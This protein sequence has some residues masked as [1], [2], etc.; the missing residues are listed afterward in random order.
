MISSD[1]KSTHTNLSNNAR[2]LQVQ[3]FETLG[4]LASNELL[5]NVMSAIVLPAIVSSLPLASGSDETIICLALNCVAQLI[6][7]PKNAAAVAK[8]GFV[9]YLVEL[10]ISRSNSASQILSETAAVTLKILH[11]L[12]SQGSHV[13]HSL[14]ANGAVNVLTQLLKIQNISG[15]ETRLACETLSVLITDAFRS[16][17]LKEYLVREIASKETFMRRL[18]ATMIAH[19]QQETSIGIPPVYETKY[20]G[21]EFTVAIRLLV[22]IASLLCS[23]YGSKGRL[24]DILLFHD[25]PDASLAAVYACCSLLRILQN[26]TY[27]E[28]RSMLTVGTFLLEATSLSLKEC[29]PNLNNQAEEIIVSFQVPQLCL[30]MCQK[31]DAT[32]AFELFDVLI[33]RFGSKSIGQQLLAEKSSLMALLNIVTVDNSNTHAFARFLGDLAKDGFLSD[34]IAV[35]G[36]R[37]S[38]IAALTSAIAS[39]ENGE[40]GEGILDEDESGLSRTCIDCLACILKNEKAQIEMKPLEASAVISTIGRSLASAVLHRFFIQASRE[41]TL[42]IDQSIDRIN[43]T[44]SSEARL[45]CAAVSSSSAESLEMLNQIG[46]LDAISL[47]AHDGNIAAIRALAKTSEIDP[48]S[49][50]TVEAHLSVMN[51][52]C[53]VEEKLRSNNN[54][55]ELREIT[56]HCVGILT[57]L[58]ENNH[59]RSAILSAEKSL[60]AIDVALQI[61][62][63][64]SKVVR[65]KNDSTEDFGT[66]ADCFNSSLEIC[67]TDVLTPS[68]W[69]TIVEGDF[70]LVRAVLSMILAYLPSKSHRSHLANDISINAIIALFQEDSA[71]CIDFQFGAVEL[72]ESFTKYSLCEHA[73]IASSLVSVI[74]QQT[75]VLQNT[76]EVQRLFMSKKIA[77]SAASGLQNLFTAIN[78]D[79]KV[80]AIAV[81]SDLFVYIVDSLFVGPKSKRLAVSLEDGILVSR[82][83]SFF[84]LAIGSA[85][86]R[87]V[88]LSIR[89]LSSM[90]RFIM[91]TSGIDSSIVL[92]SNEGSDYL[93]SAMELCLVSLSY[94]TNESFQSQMERPLSMLIEDVEPSPGAFMHSLE[95]LSS[96]KSFGGALRVV[97]MKLL[98]DI[99]SPC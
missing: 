46:G 98:S 70:T 4:A 45:L 48:R 97:G 49:I 78:D 29:M 88:L 1:L 51:V 18:V 40:G 41:T 2:Q 44:L 54:H 16:S 13:R 37:S 27:T 38:A 89:H 10:A 42:G 75:E 65:E 73:H 63:A 34:A 69:E 99:R 79:L 62:V 68:T 11:Q 52:M 32:E 61:V 22:Q 59:T 76:R 35:F 55:D 67:G 15:D 14:I 30:I 85:E 91:M 21:T 12:S 9:A 19:E 28:G 81:S 96:E 95:H 60:D 83:T 8:G 5:S 43:I 3:C 25:I 47:L 39:A 33:S 74:G 58:A 50:I 56:K 64:M 53:S 20:P 57:L 23:E 36:L 6:N 71:I 92:A 86:F 90:L 24:L 80:K 26:D 31:D 66:S 7:S 72:I 94:M 82:L 87:Q 77:S 17:E 84:L 93:D